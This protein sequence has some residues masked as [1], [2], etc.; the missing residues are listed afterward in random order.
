[1]AITNSQGYCGTCKHREIRDESLRKSLP[2]EKWPMPCRDCDIE[3]NYLWES[4]FEQ[5]KTTENQK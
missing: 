3:R 4:C 2:G 1:M 5:I